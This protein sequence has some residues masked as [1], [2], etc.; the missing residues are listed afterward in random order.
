M[1]RKTVLFNS[2]RELISVL[3]N[4]RTSQ[5][6]LISILRVFILVLKIKP[7][8]TLILCPENADF[9]ILS[10]FQ[11]RI[12]FRENDIWT[13]FEVRPPWAIQHTPNG[14]HR[15]LS[16]LS[17][18]PRTLFCWGDDGLPGQPLLHDV[19]PRGRGEHQE[20]EQEP[21]GEH[22]RTQHD[23]RGVH[24]PLHHSGNIPLPKHQTICIRCRKRR[25]SE[26]R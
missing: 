10:R 7:T 6:D 18:S 5:C 8:E 14:P 23:G 21:H 13:W 1:Q 24:D 4:Q 15:L 9:R 2:K 16:V 26:W 12:Y 19:Q 25:N 22:G 17:M 20:D 11:S 3:P